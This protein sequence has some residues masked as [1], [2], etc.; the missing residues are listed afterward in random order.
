MKHAKFRNR[1]LS[2]LLAFVLA[3]GMAV[4]SLAFSIDAEPQGGGLT[5]E[6]IDNNTVE[7]ENPF[8]DAP[9]A[10]YETVLYDDTDT[11]RVSI[12]LKE[13]STLEKG[14]TSTD[15]ATA[16]RSAMRY[17]QKLEN[18]QETMAATISRRALGGSKLDVI[19]NMTLAANIISAN[20]EY[21]QIAQIEKV[22]GV[23]AVLI[24]NQYLPCV[25]DQQE[26]ANPNMATSDKMIG[27][28]AA[29]TAGYTGAG[30]RVAI[31][32]TGT[33]V[34]HPSMDPDAFA[35]ALQ[36]DSNATIMTADDLSSEVL[37]Q[38]NAVKRIPSLTAA[39]LYVNAKI[40]FGFNYVDTD[41][42]ITHDNDEQGD[43][44]SHVAGIAA[45]NRF[46]K[47]ADGAYAS[48]LDTV[49]TQGVAPDA[50]ILTMKVFGKK[51]GA[52]DSDYMVAIEDAMVLGA[53]SA[54]LSLGSAAPGYT[55]HTEE[56]YREI[57]DH[58]V[59]SG[60]VVAI[61]AG[62]SGSWFSETVYGFPYAGS[63]GWATNGAPGSY[64][65]S[66]CVAS[67][68]NAGFTGNY[69]Q[70][71]DHKIIYT[72]TSYKN[73]PMR[74]IGGQ[75]EF[76]YL[77]KAGSAEEFAAVKDV[78]AGRIA[79]CNRGDIAFSEK[80]EAAVAN[81]AIA[82]I[83]ANNQPGS[84]N[85][86]LSSYTK[87]APC[88]SI[89]QVDGAYLKENGTAVKDSDGN[90]LYYTGELFVS[91]E[92][93]SVDLGN[94]YY[95]MSSF[96]SWGV[97]GS[98]EMKP[99]ITAP[100]GSIYSLKDGGEYQNMSGTSMASPQVAGIAALVAQYIKENGLAQK[101]GLSVRTLSQ[102][103]LMSTA[104]PV[105]ENQGADAQGNTQEG[106]YSVLQQGAGLANAGAA[107]S[108][109]SY[110]LMDPDAT[111]SY[112]DGKIKVEL[113]DDPQRTGEYTFGFTLYNMEDKD[114]SFTLDADFFTQG[115]IRV[116]NDG[117]VL[118][119]T[120]TST[121]PLAANVTWTVDGTVLKQEI[122][123]DLNGCDFNG[124]GKVTSADGQAL[125]D[126]VVGVRSEISHEN[127]ADLDKNGDI[128]TYDAY[129]FYHQ[130][131]GGV[132]AV[133]A[134]GNVHI[135][136]R[137]NV[138]GL[139]RYDADN[140][141]AGAYVEGYV[142]ANEVSSSEGLEGVSHSIPVLGYYGNWTDA[143]MFDIGSLTQYYY[144]LETRAPYMLAAFK[145]AAQLQALTVRYKGMKE[146]YAFGANLYVDENFCDED[147]YSINPETATISDFY[148]SLIRNAANARVT[149]TGSDG[150]VYLD[151]ET[152]SPMI[153]AYYHSSQR[154]WSNAQSSL[155]VN[156]EPKAAAEG[157]RLT[158]QLTL[159]PEYYVTYDG[160]TMIT[161]WDAM[162]DGASQ[163]YTMY[164]DK[165]AP[166]LH[167]VSMINDLTNGESS[168]TVTAA[169]NRYVAAAILYDY[170]S[171]KILAK[172]GGSPEGAARGEETTASLAIPADAAAE[173]L[174]LQ[175]Y[176]YANNCSTYK[177]NL[178]QSE[179]NAPVGVTLSA[180]SLHLFKGGS[181]AL[182]AEVTPFGVQPDTV[183]WSSDREDV[184]TVDEN[185]L[186]TGINEGV[187]VITATSVKDP[188]KSASCEVSVEVLK[189]TLT[190]A[191]T[192]STGVSQF[193]TWDME[194]DT[195]WTPG[196]V[197]QT[198]GLTSTAYDP[199]RNNA[200]VVDG[201]D[202][203]IHQ[204]DMTTGEVLAD[205]P[206]VFGGQFNL[207][208]YDLE[209]SSLFTTTDMPVVTSIYS[210]LILQPAALDSVSSNGFMMMMDFFLYG[211]GANNYTAMT[212]LGQTKIDLDGDGTNETD[213]ELDL[214]LDN[215]GNLWTF[216]IYQDAE[217]Y[218][219][220]KYEIAKSNLTSAFKLYFMGNNEGTPLCS[221][222]P[223]TVNG[224]LALYLSYYTGKAND[225][226]RLI[227]DAEKNFWTAEKLASFGEG[228]APATILSIHSHDEAQG[229]L[230]AAAEALPTGSHTVQAQSVTAEMLSGS[231]IAQALPFG[232][233]NAVSGETAAQTRPTAS[234]ESVPASELEVSADGAAATLRLKAAKNAPTTNGL[235]SVSYDPSVWQLS[236]VSANAQY[237]SYKNEN[238]KVLF[239][240][241][242]LSGVAANN[243]AATLT[244]TRLDGK[245]AN[246]S[247]FTIE[248]KELNDATAAVRETLVVNIS[249]PVVPQP[250]TGSQKPATPTTP[251]TPESGFADVGKNDFFYDAVE[252]AVANGVTTG[253]DATHFAPYAS[254]TRAQAVT[255]LWRAAGSP[256][257]KS[258]GMTFTD[259]K[260]G[261]Y[262]CDAVL[263]AVENGITNGTSATTFSP[264][265][266][267]SRAQIV[268]FLWRSQKSP[269]AGAANPFADVAAGAYYA[270]AVLWAVE[271]GVTT[272]TSATTF[273]PEDNCTRGQIVTFLYRAMK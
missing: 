160:D 19:W 200:I 220:A 34:D 44:G 268:T 91:A 71:G 65:N 18:S 245:N 273:S 153:G 131:S 99:E 168:L 244:F 219:Y 93:A 3:S 182:S 10:D 114:T 76:V 40:P 101:T 243:A 259:V 171:G 161:D 188:E 158:V 133:P 150:T 224:Q 237:S 103:L 85:M 229:A 149:V 204:V 138:L 128:T 166:E 95:T 70:M 232:G 6:K 135:T 189:V 148:F 41:T 185:G 104:R 210:F 211:N 4:P 218:K 66:L 264:D 106:Y 258:E 216:Q 159:A 163:V 225:L 105:V 94:D 256:A 192:D 157:D 231:N 267:C 196:A 167:N 221:M 61:S 20:V 30:S 143:S 88:V 246:G 5:W 190:G 108:S 262:Y 180:S 270:D 43:H 68:D 23:E 31:I 22:P 169:D 118:N 111:D 1:V 145:D 122:P 209:Y 132:V 247:S 234:A 69:L 36:Q 52:Y 197:I 162:G 84:S 86:D 191:L 82:T 213:A 257:P 194:N 33:D 212:S 179:L 203:A 77:D 186:V 183:T 74:T 184:A 164:I 261:S 27:S 238:G 49:M 9:V 170:D 83:V 51:G 142:F 217:G 266:T 57:L 54:N 165:T 26:T 63:V 35:Y 32:D 214:F 55:R 39:D 97:P 130:I 127:R 215:R 21:G 206:A 45:A 222:V 176:D 272:G 230:A 117:E 242:D 98:L 233:L 79:V 67:V 201:G 116:D 115:T 119:F 12:V 17:R 126:Y 72:E 207:P 24:E 107:V 80:A 137:A 269:A 252:W 89:S 139:D 226:Y 223:T 208:L 14:F 173:H 46:V 152:Q 53:D 62:N 241:V 56:K 235:M 11:V 28:S 193:Y 124:D 228:V 92:A 187:A 60:M 125:L 248:Q 251:T 172:A 47:N 260:P 136:V 140:G 113:G 48:A 38:L 37:A 129:L 147:R 110:L 227:Y 155:S 50:Q 174:L 25:L 109:G 202:K 121:A 263:W 255:F 73:A 199:V 249:Q 146:S 13:K 181:A 254:C 112:A 42:D 195:T 250:G 29:W 154:A 198:D 7:V 265:A 16:N 205:Y 177:I 123:T 8:R 102:S 178:N 15:I 141:G 2:A 239:G 240:Y 75:H 64:T 156:C 78:L 236:S 100:G 120:D 81:G 134:N 144:G 90:I 96:S 175:V 58:V 253:V 151:K 59:G 271:K 87:T